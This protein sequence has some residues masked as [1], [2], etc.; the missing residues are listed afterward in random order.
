M[1]E[2]DMRPLD[3]NQSNPVMVVED[4][5]IFAKAVNKRLT[6]EGFEIL[7]CPDLETAEKTLKEH[8]PALILLDMRLPDGSG[9]DF[10][11]KVRETDGLSV[12]VVVMTAYGEVE[13][14]VT[15]MKLSAAD[16]LKK[17]VDLE[18]L[19]LTV[20]KVLANEKISLQLEYSKARELSA[21]AETTMIGESPAMNTLKQQIEQIAKLTQAGD[22]EPPTVLITGETG[23]GKDVTA[24][25]IHRL[26]AR[27]E[28]PFV[29]VDCASLPKDLIE[30]EL[31]GH[32]K[33]AFTNAHSERVG[34]IEA[35]EDGVVFLDEIGEIPLEL[36]SKLLAVLERRRLRRVGS[37]HERE[38]A[39]WFIAATNRDVEKM[40]A[41]GA[42][43]SDL[44][45]RLNVMTLHLPP[46]RERGEDMLVLAKYFGAEVARR[47]G[48]ERFALDN[49]AESAVSN[50][51]WPGNVR[52]LRHVVERATLLS[53][54]RAL[55]NIDLMLGGSATG[56]EPSSNTPNGAS[57]SL[58]GMTLDEAEL[59]LITSALE[60]LEG[61]VSAAARELGITRMAMRY[62]MKKYGLN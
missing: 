36:Q 5:L 54:G 7:S 30:A 15:A 8:Q 26:S 29:H 22:I 28:K 42:L 1:S 60:R 24:R 9:L 61:N 57:T 52:E 39:A 38:I 48:F 11:A 25:E 51:G 10:L 31:F 50:Y 47:Y 2:T 53:G 45:F 27:A 17:P 58:A 33:G 13:D 32:T 56:V 18:D 43:R 55:Q 19:V 49:S 34:L 59:M 21:E 46:L 41:D 20:Q 23:T 40:V 12:P 16:Y 37:S 62:R 44:Y 6:K 3:G 35:A 14:A 4:E